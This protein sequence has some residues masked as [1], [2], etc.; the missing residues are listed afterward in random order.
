MLIHTF[1]H[2]NIPGLQQAKS[3]AENLIQ[4]VSTLFCMTLTDLL[5]VLYLT[6]HFRDKLMSPPDGNCCC[7]YL[8]NM[9]NCVFHTMNLCSC[10]F[11]FFKSLFLL[12]FNIL[13]DFPI[14]W[15]VCLLIEIPA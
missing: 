9:F 15:S 3:L 8:L 13:T 1:R 11:S 5:T 2:I 14:V 7:L 12:L 6:F 4:T 10:S